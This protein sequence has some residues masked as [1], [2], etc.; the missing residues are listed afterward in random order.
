[1]TLLM[2]GDTQNR[3]QQEEADPCGMTNKKSNSKNK[4]N[5]KNKYRDSSLR[6]E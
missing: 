5:D 1:M 3:Q 2:L 6:S 4:S